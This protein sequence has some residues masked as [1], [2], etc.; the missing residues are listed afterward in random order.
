MKTPTCLLVTLVLLL[1]APPG[2]AAAEA[3]RIALPDAGL[4]LTLLEGWELDQYGAAVLKLSKPGAAL[5]FY[6]AEGEPKD[7]GTH[8]RRVADQA[9]KESES[10]TP[11][12]PKRW[13]VEGATEAMQLWTVEDK[14]ARFHGIIARGGGGFHVEADV[15]VDD[16]GNRKALE[17]MLLG[18]AVRRY[19]H[20]K[21]FVDYTQGFTIEPGEG[22]VAKREKD[23][24][25]RYRRSIEDTMSVVV[26]EKQSATLAKASAEAR[27]SGLLDA[28]V[29]RLKANGLAIEIE[30]DKE[31]QHLLVSEGDAPVNAWLG[32]RL[33]INGTQRVRL[34][35]M[36]H[37]EFTLMYSALEGKEQALKAAGDLARTFR[38]YSNPGQAVAETKKADGPK[39]SIR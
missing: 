2:P 17:H 23:G 26:I 16:A 28:S 15:A 6:E 10:L 33:T 3:R 21:R 38:P 9:A 22:W 18:V 20:S 35:A 12:A 24:R 34:V 14:R 13:K 37:G 5:W 27:L 8:L 19:M 11:P 36:V 29:R 1:A 7:I 4:A 25:I 32:A 39:K 30:K 31:V